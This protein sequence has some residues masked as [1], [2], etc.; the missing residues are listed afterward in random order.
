MRRLI[1]PDGLIKILRAKKRTKKQRLGKNEHE[2][3]FLSLKSVCPENL[4]IGNKAQHHFEKKKS[5]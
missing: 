3:G 5:L 4:Y 1:F 2:H